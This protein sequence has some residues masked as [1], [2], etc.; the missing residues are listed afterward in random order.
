MDTCLDSKSIEKNKGL[1]QRW[2][3]GYHEG[4]KRAIDCECTQ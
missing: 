2:V 4:K 1:S 3:C